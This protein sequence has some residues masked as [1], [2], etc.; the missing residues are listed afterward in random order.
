MTLINAPPPVLVYGIFLELVGAAVIAMFFAVIT[1]TLVGTRLRQALGGLH[2]NMDDHFVVCG[3]GN[4]GHRVAEQIH[5]MHYPVVAME[6]NENQKS[7]APVRRSGVPVLIGDAREVANLQ[8]L[9]VGRARCLIVCTDDDIS[10]LE[11]ALTVRT[12]NPELKVVLQ[13]HD[14][15]LAARVQRAIGVG[16]SRS[17]SGLAAPAFVS[18]ALGHRVISTL[19]VGDRT[20]VVARA[21]V[22]EGSA[23]AGKNVEWLLDGPYARVLMVRRGEAETWRPGPAV[24]L[25]AGDE[26]VMV[27][28]RKALDE[29]LRRTEVARS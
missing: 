4:I 23:A 15:D 12:L 28:T 26:L 14:P 3:L 2:R 16:I 29:I 13:L 17:T 19:P 6:L 25:G 10:N 24:E 7:I 27:S 22:V 11:I 20:L 18:A 5:R 8:K 9:E 21:T 1:D